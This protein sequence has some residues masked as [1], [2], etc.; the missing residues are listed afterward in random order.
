MASQITGISIAYSTVC[1]NTDQRNIKAPRL[2]PLWEEFTSDRWILRTQRASDA[3][4]VSL[5]WR[6]H[7]IPNNKHRVGLWWVTSPILVDSCDIFI[8]MPRKNFNGTGVNVELPQSW[9][10][11]QM[12]TYSVLLAICAGNSSVTGEFPAQ[13][14]M[15]RSFDVFFDL[16]LNKQLSKQSRGWWFETPSR[17]LWHHCNA[18]PNKDYQHCSLSLVVKSRHEGSQPARK[19]ERQGVGRCGAWAKCPIPVY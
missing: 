2:W 9:W 14:P 18:W 13:R 8:D 4:N 10:R 16:R 17:S 12:E 1:S 3:A 6:H 15:K 11:H 5:W 19:T 7:Y